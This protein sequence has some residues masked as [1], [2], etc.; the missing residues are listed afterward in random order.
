[1]KKNI[2]RLSNSEDELMEM[3]WA[4]NRPMTYIEMIETPWERTWKDSYL[5]KM[6]RTLESDGLIHVC[7]SELQGKAYIRKFLPSFTKE[8]YIAKAAAARIDDGKQLPVLQAFAKETI[9]SMDSG[10]LADVMAKLVKKEN[11][12]IDEELKKKLEDIIKEI[13]ERA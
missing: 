6:L 8:E 7:G 3:L 11:K 5:L 2:Y 4:L 1:M 13:R 10:D 9:K 12:E